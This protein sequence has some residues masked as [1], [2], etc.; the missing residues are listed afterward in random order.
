MGTLLFVAMTTHVK[1]LLVVP[2]LSAQTKMA[3]PFADAG[4]VLINKWT[5]FAII[6][7]VKWMRSLIFIPAIRV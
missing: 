4:E 6:S 7:Q 3:E 2:M 1:P 5:G